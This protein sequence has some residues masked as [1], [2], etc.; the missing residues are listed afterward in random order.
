MVPSL[1]FVLCLLPNLLCLLLPQG[2]YLLIPSVDSCFLCHI[3]EDAQML[4]EKRGVES[5]SKMR[6]CRTMPCSLGGK[7]ELSWLAEYVS[8]LKIVIKPKT[9]KKMV[10]FFEIS[11]ISASSSG[12][13]LP[14]FFLPGTP[15]YD[16]QL[17]HFF[18]Y[19]HCLSYAAVSDRLSCTSL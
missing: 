9:C 18:T 19:L 15:S 14:L 16:V 7:R 3:V 17:V 1:F 6:F 10:P 4:R 13:F 5:K 8:H 11:E 2:R 12:Q